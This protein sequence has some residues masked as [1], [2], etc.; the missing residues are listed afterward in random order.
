MEPQSSYSAYREWSFGHGTFEIKNRTHAY[1]SWH[2]NQDE[3][4]VEAYSLWFHT[5]YWKSSAES[6]VASFR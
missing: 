2:R 4:A 6:V 1:F 5:R 3:Y